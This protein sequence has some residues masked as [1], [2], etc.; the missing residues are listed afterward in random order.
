MAGLASEQGRALIELVANLS[1]KLAHAPTTAQCFGLVELTDM[2]V[3][4]RQ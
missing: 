1:V 3:L 4:D 2:V